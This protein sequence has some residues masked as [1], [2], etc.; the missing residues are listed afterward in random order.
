MSAPI[1]SACRRCGEGARL[2]LLVLIGW[3]GSAWTGAA[4]NAQSV[5]PELREQ[6]QRDIRGNDLR[7]KDGPLVKVGQQLALMYRA[8][9]RHQRAKTGRPFRAPRYARSVM[10][11][12]Y[13]AIDAIAAG[14]ADRLRTDL[15][16]LGLQQPAQAGRLV[17]GYLPI[18]A[19]P[20]AA[21]LA[22]LRSAHVAIARRRAG[23]VTTQGDA[24]L[25]ADVAR[26]ENGVTGA[27]STVGVLSDSY[28]TSANAVTSAVDDIA[29]GDLPPARRIQ[30]LQDARGGTDEGRAMMQIIHDIA[31]GADLAFHTALGGQANFAQG[32]RDLATANA[33]IIVDDIFYFTEPMFQDGVIAQAV[34]EVVAAGAAYFTA[35][36]NSAQESYAS[37]FV[38]SGQRGPGGGTLHDFARGDPRQQMTIP[39]DDSISIAF[40][41]VDPYAS[42]GGEG[43]RSDL[44]IYLLDRQGH[45]VASSL[46]DNNGSGGRGATDP[47][48]FFTFT[49]DG[50][51]DANDDGVPDERF[52][53][54]I[55]LVDGPAPARIKYI[56][57]PGDDDPDD[58]PTVSIDEHLVGSPTLFGHSNAAGACTVG[59]VFWFA[60]PAFSDQFTN[61]FAVNPFSAVGGVPI[62]FR[63]DGA[64]LGT[65]EVRRKPNVVG[66]DGGNTTFFGQ[67]LNDDDDFPNFFGTSAAAPHVAAVAALML[68]F[69]P[70]REPAQLYADLEATALDMTQVLA[71]GEAQPIPEGTGFDVF[72]GHGLVQADAAVPLNAAVTQ[73][74]GTLMAQGNQVRL[75]WRE[76]GQVG[77]ERYTVERRRFD[78]AFEPVA[79]VPSEGATTYAVTTENLGLGIYTFRLRWTPS[80]DGRPAQVSPTQPRVTVGLTSFEVTRAAATANAVTLNWTVPDATTGYRYEVQQRTTGGFSP[81]TTTTARSATIEDLQPG[82]HDFRIRMQAESGAAF[83]SAIRSINLTFEGGVAAG[84]PYPNPFR[85]AAFLPVTLSDSEFVTVRVYNAHGRLVQLFGERLQEQVPSLI[86]I[87]PSAD[88]ASGVYFVQLEGDDFRVDR[89]IVLVR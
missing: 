17:S 75:T 32:I 2:I 71:D 1:D 29:S 38:D 28:D 85:E 53:L 69:D 52:N 64:P 57:F 19:I 40:Q 56:Y 50:S 37:A 61:P 33:N 18:A 34:D 55:E 48:E 24:A 84:A 36:G 44:D 11:G 31:P 3:L 45:V 80:D 42:A 51:V 7:G 35:A 30:V 20:E 22:A 66:P 46:F 79:T 68:E 77:I 49:N 73:F 59:A 23:R 81:V 15:E 72:S 14:R 89:R 78:G 88:W 74:A 54:V 70:A 6:V 58:G 63:P 67:E 5:P 12:R 82:T 76:T 27:G 10:D 8:F 9:E 39:Q 62:Y 47:I 13:V 60:T 83:S 41:W 21:Q 4:V 86:T 16:R 43:A 87:T 65:P 25:R 26:A